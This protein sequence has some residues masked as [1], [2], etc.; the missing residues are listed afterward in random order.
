MRELLLGLTGHPGVGKSRATDYLREQWGFRT[1][2]PSAYIREHSEARGIALSGR[3]EFVAYHKMLIETD[4]EVFVRYVLGRD[5]MRLCVD[6]LRVPQLAERVRQAG[7]F[8]VA[9][10]ASQEAR[11]ER[12]ALDVTRR[13]RRQPKSFEDFL[14]EEAQDTSADP[15]LPNTQAVIDMADLTIDTEHLPLQE[16]RRQLDVIVLGALGEL[17]PSDQK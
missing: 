15:R 16:V 8:I 10:C 6:G 17:D 12:A 14:A 4:P 13:G 1:V 9:L 11:Y 3:G 5:A 2:K 7:G